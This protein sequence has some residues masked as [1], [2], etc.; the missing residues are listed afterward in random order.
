MIS[1]KIFCKSGPR[2]VGR[3]SG[4]NQRTSKATKQLNFTRLIHSLIIAIL[5]LCMFL[6][7]WTK[8]QHFFSEKIL[9]YIMNHNR[10][11]SIRRPSKV[12]NNEAMRPSL[13]LKWHADHRLESNRSN[14]WSRLW[15]QF[16]RHE[17]NYRYIFFD[18][19]HGSRKFKPVIPDC[20]PYPCEYIQLY[21]T[22]LY[23][24]QNKWI[25]TAQKLNKRNKKYSPTNNEAAQN[26]T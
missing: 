2:A 17:L 15:L 7:M 10:Q 12:R 22:I 16:Q 23:A 3:L 11:C 13:R 20:R 14:Q 1:R 25:D 24:A 6:S 21:F 26:L 8:S 19:Q 4:I 9:Q 18:F 5:Q